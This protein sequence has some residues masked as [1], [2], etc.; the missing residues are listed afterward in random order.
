MYITWKKTID[1]YSGTLLLRI[2]GFCLY[3]TRQTLYS[4]HIVACSL[5]P[6]KCVKCASTR[7]TV[8]LWGQNEMIKVKVGEHNSQ[9][10]KL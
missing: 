3:L 5:T 10:S 7:K 8:H 1:Q 2:T 4:V 9:N 6:A